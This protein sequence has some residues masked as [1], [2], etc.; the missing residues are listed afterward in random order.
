MLNDVPLVPPVLQ[1]MSV[2]PPA[3]RQ[4]V[5]EALQPLMT[6]PN[7]EIADFYPLSFDQDLNG[8]KADWEA[9]VLICFIDEKRLLPAMAKLEPNL[10]PE[11]KARNVRS[12]AIK[13]VFDANGSI[14]CPYRSPSF[15]AVQATVSDS[16]MKWPHTPYTRPHIGLSPNADFATYREGF[17]SFNHIQK[18]TCIR[19]ASLFA[20]GHACVSGPLG[21]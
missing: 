18:T 2:L 5:P 16:T 19:K 15:P 4:H 21:L 17:P 9:L 3:S 20:V 6:D 12:E 14:A 8:K 7:S 13:Y 1:L 10:L 11:E